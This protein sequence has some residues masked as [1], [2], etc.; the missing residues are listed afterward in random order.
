LLEYV[1]RETIAAEKYLPVIEQSKEKLEQQTRKTGVLK[2]QLSALIEL[3]KQKED[4]WLEE[5][6]QIKKG[7]MRV[8]KKK[9]RQV[10]DLKKI[11]ENKNLQI[12]GIFKEFNELEEGWDNIPQNMKQEQKPKSKKKTKKKVKF[13][14]TVKKSKREGSSKKE[15]K[16]R[17]QEQRLHKIQKT[18]DMIKKEISP[19][20]LN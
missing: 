1:I 4:T 8:L 15:L 19:Y 18:V 17:N 3:F 14:K 16:L 12:N 7:H 6:E 20:D 13:H 2:K 11:L 10:N 9:D 5:I